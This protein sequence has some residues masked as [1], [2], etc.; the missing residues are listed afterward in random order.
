MMGW[1]FLLIGGICCR[2][3]LPR[4]EGPFAAHYGART[5]G[6]IDRVEATSSEENDDTIYAIG[7]HFDA[8]DG[9]VVQGE[10]YTTWLEM[11]GTRVTVE[12]DP[13][14]PTTSRIA[15]MRADRYPPWIAFVLFFPIA[16]AFMAGYQLRQGRRAIRLVRDGTL[17]RGRLVESRATMLTLN[18]SR[19][20]AVTFEFETPEGESH[21]VTA[22]T[23]DPGQFDGEP[24][25][26][27]VYDPS[28]P[29]RATMLGHLPGS[30]WIDSRGEMVS[31]AGIPPVA[32]LFM[33]VGCAL[34]LAS[35]AVI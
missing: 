20:H 17:A 33:P 24:G 29:S 4:M 22:R 13:A 35:L 19:V 32:Y 12:I 8:P 7:Y 15:G 26:M 5:S 11:A 25:R 10:S 18:E 31:A 9:R 3:F 6:V 27:L 1:A 21:R 34:L 14:D 16:G 28:R 30:P 23:V 2:V